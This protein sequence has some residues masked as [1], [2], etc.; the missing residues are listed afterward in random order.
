MEDI[1]Q[2]IK[3][4]LQAGAQVALVAVPELSVV[5]IVVGKPRDS[6][7]YAELCAD[8]IHPNALGYQHMQQLGWVA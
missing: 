3:T 2:L 4:S 5:G 6:S 7:V 1:R 8:R